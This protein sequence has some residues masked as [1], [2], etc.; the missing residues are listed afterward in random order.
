MFKSFG[1]LEIR[2][3]VRIVGCYD[4]ARY[5]Q[6]L[7]QMAHWNTIPS[8]L[9]AHGL[10]LSIYLPDI[11]GKNVDVSP[12]NHLNDER[13]EFEYNP[14][15]MVITRKNVWVNV[16]CDRA[17]EIKNMLGI[18]DKNFWGWHFTVCNFKFEK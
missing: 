6:R 8:Q 4:I 14:E 9:P 15:D 5:Y 7:F 18:V 11:H 16:K 1:K 17:M 10:H 12:I 13:I 3:G 2:E